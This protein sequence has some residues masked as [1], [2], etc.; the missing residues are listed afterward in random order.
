MELDFSK[1]DKLPYRGFE[2]AEERKAKDE[3]IEKG[4]VILEGEK[5]PFDDQPEPEAL[6]ANPPPPAPRKGL[7][8]LTGLD[9]KRN[10]R[11]MYRAACDFHER[12]NPPQADNPEEYWNAVCDGMCEIGRRF[13]NDPFLT[14]LLLAVF[15]ELEREYKAL[16]SFAEQA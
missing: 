6:P 10:Y 4:F 1:L 11:A 15:D 13:D 14:G 7:K 12:Y 8:P 9:P 5:T 2:S 3:W 16:A